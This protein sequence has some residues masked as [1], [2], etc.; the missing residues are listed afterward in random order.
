MGPFRIESCIPLGLS[1]TPRLGAR[2][3][4]C[5]NFFMGGSRSSASSNLVDGLF[6]DSPIVPFIELVLSDGGEDEEP[7]RNLR[8]GILGF[9]ESSSFRLQSLQTK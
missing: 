9:F 1:P 4:T 3:E 5:L 2:I 6:L 8:A 7:S